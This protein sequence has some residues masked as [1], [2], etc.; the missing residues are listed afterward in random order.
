MN[1]KIL[2][3]N[4]YNLLKY[5]YMRFALALCGIVAAV[6][7]R[8]GGGGRSSSSSSS[9]SGRSTRRSS[10]GTTTTTTVVVGA[11]GHGIYN[12]DAAYVDE[13]YYYA[14]DA[15]EQTNGTLDIIDGIK[16]LGDGLQEIADSFYEN[17]EAFLN[18]IREPIVAQCW[19]DVQKDKE[20][21]EQAQTELEGWWNRETM[22]VPTL[23]V[24]NL[25]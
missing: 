1:K 5:L 14:Y 2:L 25:Q 19:S 4:S 3:N 16:E 9:R 22:S 21:M 23:S 8:R 10:S 18:S 12:P 17:P 11:E 13:G 6:E 15:P 20:F 24:L 7:A